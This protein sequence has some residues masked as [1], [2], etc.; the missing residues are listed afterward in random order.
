MVLPGF[1][2]LPFRAF[3]RRLGQ[4]LSEDDVLDGAAALAYYFLFALFPLL[5][6]AVSLTAY[7]PL[8]EALNDGLARLRPLLPAS[9]MQ[10][11]EGQLRSLLERPRPQLLTVSLLFALYTASRG[12][13]GFRKALNRAYHVGEGRPFLRTQWL[14]LWATVLTAVLALAALSMLVLG[15]EVGAWLAMR[16]GIAPAFTLVW[17]WL[18]WPTTALVIMLV[19]ALIYYWLPDVDQEFKFVTPG[20]VTSTVLWLL[21]T[22]GFSQYADHVGSLN[23]TYGSLG[24]AVVL[25]TWLYL[26]ALIF[27]LGGEINAVIEHASPEGKRPG[28]KTFDEPPSWPLVYPPGVS[29]RR[30]SVWRVQLLRL[31]HRPEK[32][33]P[34]PPPAS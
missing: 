11:I 2:G 21:A 30:P 3:L 19:A 26:G 12:L 15:G 17:S 6:F 28:A 29:R 1:K 14:A 24:A 25:L 33:S 16:L 23:V 7:L 32:R 13:D 31:V 10:L 8:G 20:S 5:L 22:W 34:P 18:R 9:S 4:S 27:I